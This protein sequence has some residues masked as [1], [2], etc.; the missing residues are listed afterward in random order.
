[1][2][3]KTQHALIDI[4][5]A[6]YA[7]VADAFSD[8]RQDPWPGWHRALS[9]LERL[10]GQPI[11]ILD[12]GCGNGRFAGFLENELGGPFCY[13]GLDSSSSL[14]AHAR[15]ALDSRPHIEFEQCEILDSTVQ[16]APSGSRFE[17]IGLFGVLHHVPGETSRRVLL[18]QL[19]SQLE[20]GGI[21]IATAW[22]FGAFERF[23]ARILPWEK[24]NERA[25][26]PIEIR[27]LEPGDHLLPWGASALPRY[28]HFT[29][30]DELRSLFPNHGVEWVDE[31]SDDGKTGDLNRY[32]VVRREPKA[33]E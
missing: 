31:F 3:A 19:I 25:R 6:F 33:N 21:L 10:S 28:C 24:Y 20:V 14:L 9:H 23:R 13:L 16:L 27:E 4:N 5:R 17:L 11:S 18:H 22:Q 7:G 12:V 30:P 8:S 2:N 15:A 26:E 32:A 29:T 1:M